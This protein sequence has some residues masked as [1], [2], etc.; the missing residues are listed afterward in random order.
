M[1]YFQAQMKV[2][3]QGEK[4]VAEKLTARGWEVVDVRTSRSYQAADVDFRIFRNNHK[5]SV[6]VKTDNYIS[7]TNNIAVEMVC[8]ANQKRNGLGWFHYTEADLLTYVCPYT[9]RIWAL[10]MDELRQYIN[11][12]LPCVDKTSSF[13]DGTTVVNKLIDLNDYAN[14]GYYL[15]QLN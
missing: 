13:H 1:S 4:L 14:Q 2:G 9:E 3:E 11:R 15:Q 12:N 6:E 10:N 7:S 8:S 5:L